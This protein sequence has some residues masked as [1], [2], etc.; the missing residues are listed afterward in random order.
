MDGAVATPGA[1]ALPLA[2]APG[3]SILEAIRWVRG[4]GYSTDKRMPAALSVYP[5]FISCPYLNRIGLKT[6]LSVYPH[7]RWGRCPLNIRCPDLDPHPQP[8]PRRPTAGRQGKGVLFPSPV[9][10]F[11]A[12]GRERVGVKA[13]SPRLLGRKPR[14]A[15][16]R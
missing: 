6:A 13:A 8:F 14:A 1:P 9:R 7:L 3:C 16:P 10:G 2:G 5:L 12:R 15:L 4:S 11:C